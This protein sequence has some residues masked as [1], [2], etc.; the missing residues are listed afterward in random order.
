MKMRILTILLFLIFTKISLA[1]NYTLTIGEESYDV[2]LGK[3]SRIKIDDRY[4]TIKL[5]KKDIFTYTT[6][7]FSFQ[8]S[9]QYSPSKTDLGSDIFQT[10]MM[11]PL[12]TVI[13]VQEYLSLDPTVLMDLMVEK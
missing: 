8:H 1:A 3:E 5:E 11:T 12:G 6:E 4:L 7:N 9:M 13:M 10:A 2:S